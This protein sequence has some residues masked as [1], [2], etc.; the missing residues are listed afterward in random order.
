I[1]SPLLEFDYVFSP[2]R[3]GLWFYLLS[4]S[5][6]VCVSDDVTLLLFRHGP[7]YVHLRRRYNYISVLMSCKFQL[8]HDDLFWDLRKESFTCADVRFFNFQTKVMLLETRYRVAKMSLSL[9]TV[10]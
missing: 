4:N 9:K 1:T 2:Q 10:L 8:L 5:Y 3:P 7:P 6:G